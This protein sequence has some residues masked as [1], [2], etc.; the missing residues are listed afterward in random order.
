MRLTMGY[1]SAALWA[2]LDWASAWALNGLA[3]D[4]PRALPLGPVRDNIFQ[5]GT[6]EILSA[7]F[8][9]NINE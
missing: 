7:D 9:T 8:V 1:H 5:E 6:F 4:P 3:L 2:L